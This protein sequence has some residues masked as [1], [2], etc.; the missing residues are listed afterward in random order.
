L[1]GTEPGTG[2]AGGLGFGVAMFLGG[3]LRPGA[4]T[5]LDLI[6]FD[7]LAHDADLVLTGEGSFDQQTAEGKLI[8]VLGKA[9]GTA[10][11][12][13]WC[14]REALTTAWTSRELPRPLASRDMAPDARTTSIRPKRRCE[15]TRQRWRGW[16]W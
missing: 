12:A 10:D 2:A 9:C 7:K 15:P 1:N 14:L 8:S 11:V 16:S 6:G 13:W 5:V 4:L 3:Q